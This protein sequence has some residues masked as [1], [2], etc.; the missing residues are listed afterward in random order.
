M[1]E[2]SENLTSPL[3]IPDPLGSIL[4]GPAQ[5]FGGGVE[6][7][8]ATVPPSVAAEPNRKRS[9]ALGFEH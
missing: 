1:V 3:L 8:L 6:D 4:V 5:S 7:S 9:E 2:G